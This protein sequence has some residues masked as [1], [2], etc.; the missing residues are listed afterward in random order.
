[1]N[2]YASTSA[3]RASASWASRS[4]W[5]GS[6][7]AIATRARIV[8]GPT[9]N[10]RR[11]RHGVVGPAASRDQIPARQRG[12]C[13]KGAMQ[14]RCPGRALA[15]AGPP[16]SRPA[17]PQH[18]RRPG[19]RQPTPSRP[20][21]FKAA[22][23]GSGLDGRI[24]GGPG[25]GRRYPGAPA[26]SPGPRGYPPSR[27]HRE[28]PRPRRPPRRIVRPLRPDHPDELYHCEVPAA[29]ARVE[30]VTD[31]VGEVASFFGGRARRDRVTD[32][33]C[34]DACAARIWLSRHRSSKSR[35]RPI[36]SAKYEPGRLCV[37]VGGDKAARGQSPDQQG[38]VIGL[39][40]DRQSLLSLIQAVG[41]AQ[42]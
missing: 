22:K 12:L 21:R 35:A 14:P 8:S 10:A 33:E 40:R 5:S 13:N 32:R 31:R 24:G 18:R 37:E 25:R 42:P 20:H 30:P 34:R 4:A 39:A 28:L 29:Q 26:R 17:P 1:M 9:G 27:S 16:P 38:R 3:A 6:P 2:R 19:P 36:A 23:L 41:V 11:C 7:C 15:V